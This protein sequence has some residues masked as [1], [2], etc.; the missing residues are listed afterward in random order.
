MTEDPWLMT[1]GRWPIVYFGLKLCSYLKYNTRKRLGY[2][3][4]LKQQC[5][6]LSLTLRIVVFNK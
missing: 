1:D 5:A 6:K 3:S 2:S 4:E